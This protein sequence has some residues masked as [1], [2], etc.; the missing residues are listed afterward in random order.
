MGGGPRRAAPGRGRG[1]DTP[2]R[3]PLSEGAPGPGLRPQALPRDPAR[4]QG[5]AAGWPRTSDSRTATSPGAGPPPPTPAPPPRHPHPEGSWRTQLRCP[6]PGQPAAS[7]G[8]SPP[9]QARCAGGSG[10]LAP[11]PAL[12]MGPRGPAH[13]PPCPACWTPAP[14]CACGRDPNYPASCQ[15]IKDMP[16]FFKTSL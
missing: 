15:E 9:S 10:P 3:Q 6:C 12:P 7:P 13:S 8:S 1:L 11:R 16:T 2:A 14:N 4:D 5:V